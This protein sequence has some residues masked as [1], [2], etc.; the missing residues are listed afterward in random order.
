MFVLLRYSN[1]WPFEL[2][3]DPLSLIRTRLQTQG[4]VLLKLNKVKSKTLIVKYLTLNEPIKSLI[5]EAKSIGTESKEAR[6]EINKL[7]GELEHVVRQIAANS[8][9]GHVTNDLEDKERDIRT[10]IEQSKTEFN[11]AV[12]ILK[13]LKPKVDHLQHALERQRIK[14]HNEFESWFQVSDVISY[15]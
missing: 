11:K 14:M 12:S 3:V 15:R 4:Q 9:V 1:V 2:M 13:Q 5:S 7:K 8:A 6:S 10:K